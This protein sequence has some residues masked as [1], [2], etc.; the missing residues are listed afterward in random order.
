MTALPEVIFQKI[1][2]ECPTIRELS[3]SSLNSRPFLMPSKIR[4][5]ALYQNS[6]CL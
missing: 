6:N 4:S 2:T 3:R 1:A 5:Q